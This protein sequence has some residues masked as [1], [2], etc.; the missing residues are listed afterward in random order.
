MPNADIH[1]SGEI[2]GT[3]IFHPETEITTEEQLLTTAAAIAF[4]IFAYN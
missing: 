2:N 1:S 3:I 4:V